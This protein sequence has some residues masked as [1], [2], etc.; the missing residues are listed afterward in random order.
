MKSTYG[1][2]MSDIHDRRNRIACVKIDMIERAVLFLFFVLAIGFM[3][4]NGAQAQVACPAGSGCS[5]VAVQLDTTTGGDYRNGP[6][7]GYGRCFFLQPNPAQCTPGCIPNGPND[8]T[9]P[10]DAFFEDNC[11][12]QPVGPHGFNSSPTTS[13]EYA[14]FSQ[15]SVCT[16]G[17]FTPG[18]NLP[19]STIDWA[20]FTG[21]QSNPNTGA[22]FASCDPKAAQCA[23]AY[24]YHNSDLAFGLPNGSN[25]APN[26]PQFIQC[27]ANNAGGFR[28]TS[29]DDD[30]IAFEPQIGRA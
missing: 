5:T 28:H 1:G 7:G 26:A 4:A 27:L 18:L 8:L 29:F 19:S 24:D 6:N 15:F 21:N 25:A 20:L 14:N 23:F 10:L 17:E 13:G 11:V 16:G 9:C 2:L 3:D 12:Q 30:R 22:T